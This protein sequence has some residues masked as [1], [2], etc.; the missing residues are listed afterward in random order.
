[1]SDNGRC[2]DLHEI[3][4]LLPA[5]ERFFILQHSIRWRPPEN[6]LLFSAEPVNANEISFL[7][8]KK[9]EKSAA[10]WYN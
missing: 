1:M 4:H 2:L 5:S 6:N 3:A 9:E 8:A 7:W 10:V